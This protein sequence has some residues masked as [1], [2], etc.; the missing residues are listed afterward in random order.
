[1]YAPA[2]VFRTPDALAAL[3]AALAPGGVLA[4]TV[5]PTPSTLDL[6]PSTIYPQPRAHE[7]PPGRPCS[8]I[9][10]NAFINQSKKVN[11]PTTLSTSCLL[12]LRSRPP[13]PREAF[14]P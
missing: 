14:L 2:A 11:S 6:Q 4:V 8:V 9:L 12:L 3:A 5:S 1:M 13:S 7:P 10:Q